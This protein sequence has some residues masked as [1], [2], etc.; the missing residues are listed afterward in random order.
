MA[1][2]LDLLDTKPTG[3]GGE[4]PGEFSKGLRAGMLGAGS[5]LQS[6]GAGAAGA[7]GFDQ[8]AASQHA[9]AQQLAEE[10]QRVGPRV[11]SFR[12]VGSLR[13]ALDYGAGLA[14]QA[15]PSVGLGLGAG[16]LTA[17]TGGGAAAAM[18]AGGLA[19]AP[20]E[21]GDVIQRQQQDPAA[22]LRSAGENFGQAALI[23]GASSLAQGIVPGAVGGK[24][25]GAGVRGAEKAA[26]GTLRAAILRDAAIEGLSEGG[27]EALKQQAVTPGQLQWD[28]IIDNAV[29]GALIGGPLGGVGH[30]ADAAHSVPGGIGQGLKDLGQFAA[31]KTQALAGMDPR[32]MG[33]AAGGAARSGVEKS[34]ELAGKAGEVAAN[35]GGATKEFAKGFSEGADLPGAADTTGKAAGEML[36]R[37]RE[38]VKPKEVDPSETG[39]VALST[40][41]LAEVTNP[42]TGHERLKELANKGLE[43]ASEIG[44][45][46][47]EWISKRADIDPE[48]RDRAA[49]LMADASDEAARAW[50]ATTKKALELRDTT[51]QQLKNLTEAVTEVAGKVR[52]K[53]SGKKSEDFSGIRQVIAERLLPNLPEHVV[54]DP[55]AAQQ[56]AEATRQFISTAA[57]GNPLAIERA[58]NALRPF[59]GENTEDV[60]ADVYRAVGDSNPKAAER[61][62]GALNQ[63]KEAAGGTRELTATVESALPDELKANAPQ[64]TEALRDWVRGRNDTPGSA[65]S[66]FSNTAIRQEIERTFGKNADR[67]FKALEKDMDAEALR[68][69]F[70]ASEGMEG[71]NRREAENDVAESKHGN[72]AINEAEAE[73]TVHSTQ[74]TKDGKPVPMQNPE[75]YA[76]R[77][78]NVAPAQKLIDRLTAQFKGPDGP[79]K[80]ARW[81]SEA[82]FTGNPDAS[83][84]RGFV[85]VDDMPR[86]GAISDAGLRTAKLDRS[87]AEGSPSRIDVPIAESDRQHFGVKSDTLVLDAVRLAREG[88]NALKKTRASDGGTDAQRL[89]RGFFEAVSQ[90]YERFGTAPKIGESTVIGYI[91]NKPFTA[92]DAKRIDPRSAKD[93]ETDKSRQRFASQLA[94]LR[95]EY[96]GADEEGK[97]AIKER[98]AEML[99]RSEDAKAKSMLAGADE[100]QLD[101]I[102]DGLLN[103]QGRHELPSDANIHELLASKGK[104]DTEKGLFDNAVKTIRGEQVEIKKDGTRLSREARTSGREEAS[105]IEVQGERGELRVKERLS[106]EARRGLADLAGRDGQIAERLL[107]RATAVTRI[108]NLMTERERA[109]LNRALGVRNPEDG[110]DNFVDR[111]ARVVNPLFEKYKEQLKAPTVKSDGNALSPEARERQAAKEAAEQDAKEAAEQEGPQRP[112]AEAAKKAALSEAASSSDPALLREI[113]SS[114]DA[115]GLQ[116]SVQYLNDTLYHGTRAPVESLVNA[117]GDLVLKPRKNFGGKTNGVSFTDARDSAYDYAIRIKGGGP[118]GITFKNAKLLK[119]KGE[120]LPNLTPET[121]REFADYS[122][123]D[124]V[125]P[126]GMYEIEDLHN[127]VHS[128]EDASKDMKD[129]FKENFIDG[130]GNQ[131]WESIHGDRTAL[132]E[133]QDNFLR[134]IVD[135][136]EAEWGDL[137]GEAQRILD[138]APRDGTAKTIDAIN[139]RLDQLVQDPDTAY[140]M[141]RAVGGGVTANAR[142]NVEKYVERV[143]GK[144]VAVEWANIP[145]AGEYTVEKGQAILRLS[146]H[147]LNPQSAAYHEALHGFFGQIRDSGN[148]QINA[149]LEKA[150]SQGRVLQ[151]MQNHFKNEPAVLRQLRSDP[152]ERAAYMYQLWASDKNFRAV[153][154]PQA[155]TIF[156]RVAEAV[157]KV[158]GI[159]SNDQRALH[160]LEHFHFGEYAKNIGKPDVTELMK[161]GTNPAIEKARELTAPLMRFYDTVFTTGAERLRDTDITPIREIADLIHPPL[162]AGAQRQGWLTASREQ[163]ATRMNAYATAV[164]GASKEDTIAALKALQTGNTAGLSAGAQH[165]VTETRK[166]LQETGAYMRDKGLHFGDLGEDYFPRVWDPG[167]LAKRQ[168][169]FLAMMDKYVQ[170]GEYKGD[171]HDLLLKLISNDGMNLDVDTRRPGMQN[172]KERELSFITGDEAEPFLS[173]DLFQT[174]NSYVSQATRRA[175]WAARFGHDGSRLTALLADAKKEGATTEQLKTTEQYIK[176]VIGTLG[177]GLNPTARRLMGN[178]IVYQNVRLLPLAIFSSVV[179]P[180]GIVVRGG[181]VSDAFSAFKR[182]VRE[183]PKNFKSYDANRDSSTALAETLGVIDNAAL[184]HSVGALYSQ[185]MV[186]DTARKWNDTF[187]R[188]NL[189]EQFNT[190]MRVGATEAALKFIQ[191]QVD[192]PGP[193]SERWL[194]ELGL[195]KDDVQIDGGRVK[196]F[197]SEGLSAQHE[198]KMRAAVNKWVDG[199]V[200][201]PNQ[202]DKPIW[203]ND[204]HFMLVAHL[205]QFVYAFQHTIIDRV[206]HEFKEGNYSPAMALASYVPIMIASDYMKGFIQ[207]GGEQPAWKRDWGVSDWINS[208]VERAGLYGV[209]QFSTDALHGNFGSLTGPTIEQ[210]GDAV[211]VLGG[212]ERFGDFALK[213]LP[214]NSLYKGTVM[215]D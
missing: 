109:A 27:G 22:R 85:V 198:A 162:T 18:L 2:G 56:V 158:L 48:T 175:E 121:F 135:G 161:K 125:I 43:K 190:S 177:D 39:G 107:K 38:A 74:Y 103:G 21:I 200:L 179:D 104:L 197:Q 33:Q 194:S 55:A 34:A 69:Q 146:I 152:E 5:Q 164:Q 211:S 203:M 193:H 180:V 126:K 111:V 46:T 19:Q 100:Q 113:A 183:I 90:L 167:M 106:T 173:K 64:I 24:L 186:G 139:D 130:Y 32:S 96:R 7:M 165:V 20:L 26:A 157:R 97:A 49:K 169:E 181:T 127:P 208:G 99:A 136:G 14:G 61:F 41:E 128:F 51:S 151:Y 86:E 93:R 82:E 195:T 187:F 72:G 44:K 199:A 84:E 170:T 52:E 123:E 3:P 204:P 153:L 50:G 65:G 160:I 29:G 9:A 77:F 209:G 114:T 91:G 201:R 138:K 4:G 118:D 75:L 171:P 214:A 149:V 207:G 166:L 141:Q 147:A 155:T 54:N 87:K 30:V 42:A 17:A 31:N 98:A 129:M 94:K 120:A 137:Y 159:W 205:K 143:L 89:A 6:F 188:F 132:K 92:G 202:A 58:V 131:E 53:A 154:N 16:A 174:V 23:G 10:A 117:N 110:P 66:Q 101:T 88:Q 176:G 12:D 59:L 150:A 215:A 78:D 11:G 210:L 79:T 35:M 36:N 15:V 112:K 163:R 95:E 134:E 191:R 213:S 133:A 13:D 140:S 116:R 57:E 115:R 68:S 47:G 108:Q 168:S 1:L 37:F 28:P 70:D 63:S 71:Q 144:S 25:L 105:G 182:G 73:R 67:V 102:A 145:H 83:R 189:M 192:K 76:S 60:L 178:A 45:K 185:G 122:G 148:H 172:I 212:K 8:F 142:A 119:I 196:L 156:Q 206:V 62:F 124:V 80:T 40:D 184:L 81:I